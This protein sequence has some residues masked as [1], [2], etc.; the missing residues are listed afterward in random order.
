MCS[1]LGLSE[2]VLLFLGGFEDKGS[3]PGSARN[4]PWQR[5]LQQTEIIIFIY[6]PIILANYLPKT[7]ILMDKMRQRTIAEGR[8]FMFSLGAGENIRKNLPT[9]R[10]S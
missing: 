4:I 8:N 2:L 9:R 10:S 7:V 1:R 3:E 6:F 5:A